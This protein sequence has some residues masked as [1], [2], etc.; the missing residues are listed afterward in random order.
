MDIGLF[1]YASD[2]VKEL[3]KDKDIDSAVAYVWFRDYGEHDP[4]CVIL[5]DRTPELQPALSG[6]APNCKQATFDIRGSELAKKY[7]Y[8][9]VGA[10]NSQMFRIIIAYT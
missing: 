1:Q 8:R 4:N 9:A 5:R 10:Q 7:G 3:T 6:M 2:W